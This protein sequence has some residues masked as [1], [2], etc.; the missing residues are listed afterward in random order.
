MSIGKM[1]AGKM[2]RI[3]RIQWCTVHGTDQ[4]DRHIFV[5]P[6]SYLKVRGA[7]LFYFKTQT[8]S[9]VVL[10]LKNI[11]HFLLRE[12]DPVGSF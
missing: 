12:R 1:S 11:F 6:K 5:I 3:Q 2:S 8:L 4:K 10:L 7:V 9:Y